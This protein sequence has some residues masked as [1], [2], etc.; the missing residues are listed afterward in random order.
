MNIKKICMVCFFTLAIFSNCEDKH[1]METV[2]SLGDSK[3][4]TTVNNVTIEVKPIDIKIGEKVYIT[5]T[6]AEEKKVLIK[7]S[8]QSLGYNETIS[9]PSSLIKEINIEGVHDLTF[10]FKTGEQRTSL[11]TAINVTK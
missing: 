5:A 1:S 10:E 11:S 7:L 3:Y 9:T 4:Q 8:S 6:H 2:I